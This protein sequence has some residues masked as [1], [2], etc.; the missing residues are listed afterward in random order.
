MR[1]TVEPMDVPRQHSS[2][3]TWRNIIATWDQRKRF[4]R[5][6]EQKWK[7]DPHL[8]DDIG[9]TRPQVEAELAKPFWRA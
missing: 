6:L 7:D 1:D 9:L 5:D 2:L 8:I 3:A 4:R